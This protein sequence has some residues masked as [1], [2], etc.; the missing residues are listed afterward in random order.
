MTDTPAP[1]RVFLL[2][3]CL[4]FGAQL[5]ITISLPSLPAIA[6]ELGL[7]GHKAALSV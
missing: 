7:D 5:G 2:A 4:V 1:T 6:A 3:L